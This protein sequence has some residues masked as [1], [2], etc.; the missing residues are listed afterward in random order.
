MILKK[1]HRTLKK[2]LEILKLIFK[3]IKEYFKMKN[4]KETILESLTHSD[5]GS[6]N[7]VRKVVD[8]IGSPVPKWAKWVRNIGIV[9]VAIGGSVA[10][11]GLAFPAI[12]ISA[13]PYMVLVGNTM[14]VIGQTFKK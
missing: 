5:D 10:T 1:L 4:K 6:L 8:Q 7:V 14:T 2:L 13:S 11:S 12:I 9:L 3:A